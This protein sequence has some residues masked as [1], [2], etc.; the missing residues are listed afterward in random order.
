MNRKTVN[1]KMAGMQI[2]TCIALALFF[3]LL[4]SHFAL[5]APSGPTITFVNNES[6]TPQPAALLNTSGGTI[7]TV[8]LN[9]T[10]QNLRWKA[11]VGNITG[12]LTLD[13]ASDNTIFDWALTEVNGEIY[14]TRQQAS[15]NWT[16]INCSNSTH[17]EL[18]N[19][20]MNHT[21]RDDNITAT[22][23]SQTHSAFYAGTSE[24][25]ADTCHSV[26][27]Y[28]NSSSQQSY[29][30]E[31]VLYDGTNVSNG[32]IVYATPLEKD[33]FGFDNETYDFQMILPERGLP[34][35]TG[36]TAYYFYVEL[37]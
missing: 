3:L 10:S 19:V 25:L 4:Q 2:T 9:V 27:T 20:A 30:E 21:N 22:F 34:T 31:V 17:I 5:S 36:S 24:I 26:Y 8:T 29:F 28:V 15:I 35:W 32:N 6:K 23:S 37:N 16:G 11:Y 13:D 7:T 14:A 1:I 18:E 33:V 12:T